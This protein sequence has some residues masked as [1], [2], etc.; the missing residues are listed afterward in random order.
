MKPKLL[1]GV[2][3]LLLLGLVLLSQTT[4]AMQTG[5]ATRGAMLY[6]N[7]YA[8]LGVDAP[9]GDMPL[10][11]SQS[12]NT[13]SGPDTWRCV[14]CHGWDYQG[15]DGANRSGSNYTGFPGVVGA[16]ELGAAE[17]AAALQGQSN[18][19][20]D[21]S[22]Y[23]NETDLADL[24]EF[25][26][27]A[28]ID[29]SQYIDLITFKV[30]GGDSAAGQQLYDGECAECH[31]ADGALLKFRYEGRDATLGT[32]AVLDPWRFLHKTRYGTPGTEM[33]IGAD[34]GWTPEDGRDVLLY[35]QS[36][37]S[38]LEAEEIQPP[39]T[40]RDGEGSDLTGGPASGPLSG[41]ATALGA[42]VTSLGFAVLLGAFLVGVIFV[43]VWLIRDRKNK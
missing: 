19:Q 16:K 6:D 29:D 31:G 20:H 18:P 27:T 28:V 4:S 17:I 34:L 15:K 3:L 24:A 22:A 30:I 43:V 39:M 25:L 7:W 1:I 26:Q 35:A 42:M 32:L 8:V 40:G 36:L 13:R 41:I 14:T 11:V 9:S 38:G 37:P 12:S 21:F 10:W 23:L 2:G 33:V 5:A